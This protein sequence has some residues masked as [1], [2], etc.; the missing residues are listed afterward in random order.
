MPTSTPWRLRT[1]RKIGPALIVTQGT[2]RKKRNADD[3]TVQTILVKVGTWPFAESQVTWDEIHKGPPFK[4]GGPFA[5]MKTTVDLGIQGIVNRKGPPG[6]AGGGFYWNYAGGFARPLLASDAARANSMTSIAEADP[7]ESGILV[8]E[9]A[10][11]SEAYDRLRP[12]LNHA[13]ASVFLYEGKDTARMLRT[14]SAFFKGVFNGFASPADKKSLSNDGSWIKRYFDSLGRLSSRGSKG[15]SNHYL[16]HQFGWVPFVND[17][18]KLN[19][20]Y[21]NQRRYIEQITRDNGNW[22]RRVRTISRERSESLISTQIN[23]GIGW[24]PEFD[25]MVTIDPITGAK[26][27]MTQRSLKITRIWAAGSFTYYRPEFDA[28]L[29]DYESNWNEAMRMLTLYG[30]RINPAILWKV[31]PWTWLIDWFLGV[32]TLIDRAVSWGLDGVVSRYMYLMKQTTDAVIHTVN[33]P[34]KEGP[35]SMTW[36]SNFETKQREVANGNFS[37][38]LSGDLTPRQLAIMAALGLSRSRP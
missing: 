25:Q 21:Q 23:S 20:T 4:S 10:L 2:L 16:N 29:S 35:S 33:I 28:T 38:H 34:W 24:R 1:R 31:T 3:V 19:E 12:K 9:E 6:G 30:A 7:Y 17:I 26:Y 32:G 18:L 37:F 15:V 11:G 5:S 36:V 8:S 22:I 13:D 14:S 27:T